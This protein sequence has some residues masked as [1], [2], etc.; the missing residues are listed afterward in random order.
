MSVVYVD[1]SKDIDAAL[2][3]V[4]SLRSERDALKEEI[5]SLD[6]QLSAAE[7]VFWT[8]R[9]MVSLFRRPTW[10]CRPFAT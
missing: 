4:A 2:A 7:E 6:G 9:T 10:L 5:S 3:L 1:Q 8:R